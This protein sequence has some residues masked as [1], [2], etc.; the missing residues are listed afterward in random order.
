M[1]EESR[2]F[3]LIIHINDPSSLFNKMLKN[4]ERIKTKSIFLL[5]LL[6]ST[7]IVFPSNA[8]IRIIMKRPK[9]IRIEN[10]KIDE[11]NIEKEFKSSSFT[12]LTCLMTSQIMASQA[13]HFNEEEHIC[14]VIKKVSTNKS[15]DFE[16]IMNDKN[17]TNGKSV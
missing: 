8:S 15:E 5:F 4:K 11:L 17:T 10:S 16:S 6:T 3:I 13:Y 2:I 7:C 9:L 14:Q 1:S 12:R